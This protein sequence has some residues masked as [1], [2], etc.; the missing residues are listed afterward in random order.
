MAVFGL[1]Y[2][3]LL[4]RKVGLRR[5]HLAAYEFHP[6]G[7]SFDSPRPRFIHITR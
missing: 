6:D 7:T 4:P 5:R 3:L 1:G 2:L